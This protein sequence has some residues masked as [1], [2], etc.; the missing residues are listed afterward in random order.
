MAMR[1][2]ERHRTDRVGWLRAAV[3]GANDGIISTASLLLGVSAANATHSD[4]LVAG[5]AGLVAGAMS[6]AAGEYVSVQSQV[7]TEQADLELERKE[8]ITDPSGEHKELAGLYME[9]GLDPPLAKQVAGQLMARDA[10]G[11]HAREELGISETLRARPIQA[12][13]ASASSFGIGAAMPLLTAAIVQE[14][15]VIPFVSGTSL[16]FL[17]GLG[18][19]AAY[20]GGAS[21]MKGSMRVTLWG[22]LAMGLTA[23]IGA[24]IGPVA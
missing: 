17:S 1:H 5:M 11:A 7:D 6:M 10:L 20:A 14:S 13:L 2:R 21:I 16:L 12:A 23:G 18:G 19:L 3:L 9:R 8:L 24:L 22:A 15:H 4:V